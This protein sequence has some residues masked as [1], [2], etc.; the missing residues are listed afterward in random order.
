MRNRHDSNANLL[1]YTLMKKKNNGT[2]SNL[3]IFIATHIQ[4]VYSKII[5]TCCPVKEFGNNL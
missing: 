1:Q 3:P 5:L 2:D 4:E